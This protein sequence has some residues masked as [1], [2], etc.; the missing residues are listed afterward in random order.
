MGTFTVTLKEAIKLTGGTTAIDEQGI[1]SLTGGNIG[2]GYYP[3]FDETYRSRLNGLILDHFWNRE[4]GVE[5]VDMFQLAMRRKLNEIMPFYNQ[6]YESTKVAYGP[7]STIDMHTVSNSGSS[8][9]AST[10]ATNETTNGVVSQSRS[11][12]SETPQ[13]MLS[14]NADYATGAAD[15]QGK[16]D[17]TSNATENNTSNVDASANDDSTVTGYQGV[18]SEL[19]M[20][21][22]QSLVNIDLMVLD[23]LEELFMSVWNT[24]DSYTTGG[25]FTWL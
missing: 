6:L 8:Q 9:T 13:T 16:N 4:I 24:G 7:L 5:S 19:I 15:V 18:A 17:T 23:E 20:R 10:D 22:R 25:Y 21:Y 14:G 12:T 1:T 11:V 2:I 3:I